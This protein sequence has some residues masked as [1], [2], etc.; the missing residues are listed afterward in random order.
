MSKGERCR[1]KDK[2]LNIH[3]IAYFKD[4]E[5]WD[6]PNGFL[7]TL[8]EPCHKGDAK[9]EIIL[10]ISEILNYIF[11]IKDG[12]HVIRRLFKLV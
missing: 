3:H 12:L 4:Y 10:L 1:A 11:S 5:P 7:I 6:T 9:D 2:T 8:C